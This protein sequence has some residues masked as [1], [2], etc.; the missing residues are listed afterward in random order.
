MILVIL[1][2]LLFSI[3]LLYHFCTNTPLIEN[4]DNNS[5]EDDDDYANNNSYQ[6][7]SNNPLFIALKNAANIS[8]LKSKVAALDN[9]KEQVASISEQVQTND[10]TLS[11]I[12]EHINELG[13]ENMGGIPA[14][15]KQMPKVTGL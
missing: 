8:T 1:I 14:Q 7:Q 4:I 3:I 6:N 2:L 11:R 13:Y 12:G 15:G 10:D 9:L 5:E